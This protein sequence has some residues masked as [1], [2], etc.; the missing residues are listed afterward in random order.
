MNKKMRPVLDGDFW[1]IGD[2]PDLGEL[3][4]L[5]E[6][7]DGR[8]PQ[9]CVDHHVFQSIDGGWHLWGC[10]RNTV[11]G[12]ILYHWRSKDLTDTHWEKTGEIIRADINSG[13]SVNMVNGDEWIQSPFVIKKGSKFYF[14]YGGHSAGIDENGN[15]FRKD[16]R[17]AQC[18]IS[19]MTSLDGRNWVRYFN[20]DYQ[21]RV[22]VG[23]GETRD[24][25]LIK[26]DNQWLLYYAG[27]EF[28][29][30]KEYPGFYVRSSTDFINWSDYKLVHRD[31]DPKFGEGKWETECPHVVKRQGYYYLFRTQN[32]SKA[33][34]HVFRS[35]DPYNFGIDN[36]EEKYI[37]SIE[38]GAP[39]II[40][41]ETGQEYITSNHELI[42]G[43]KICKLKWGVN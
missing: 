31:L 30:G 24:P 2:N 39:E 34:T 22:F 1:M 26:I 25:C 43:T 10:I 40:V 21:S 41:D 23:P 17:R 3:Q 15:T 37:G 20:K 4:G 14:Y 13:E 38:V 42:G 36:A 9:E 6:K 8:S 32:Y 7:K 35:K 18:Q 16:S 29:D 5:K 19:L 27:Y 28:I 11:V 12:R 33:I